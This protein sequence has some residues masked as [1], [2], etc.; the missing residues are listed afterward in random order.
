MIDKWKKLHTKTCK[1]CNQQCE[2]VWRAAMFLWCRCAM[3]YWGRSR[4]F[5]KRMMCVLGR[6]VSLRYHSVSEWHQLYPI[7]AG[8]FLAGAEHQFK[9]LW[10]QTG[11]QIPNIVWLNQGCFCNSP[12]NT[13]FLQ[14]MKRKKR[15]VCLVKKVILIAISNYYLPVT[16]KSAFIIKPPPLCRRPI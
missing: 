12:K 1:I 6:P 9:Y 16:V 5:S 4:L 11:K 3:W 13:K 7:Q 8:Q 14:N 15:F 10:K 2:N